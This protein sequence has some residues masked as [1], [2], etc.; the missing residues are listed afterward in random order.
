[1]NE[2]IQEL[3]FQ[4]EDYADNIVDMG[5]EFYE[6]YTNKFAELI[7]AECL[8]EVCDEVQY[9]SDWAAADEV[10]ARVRKHFGFFGVEEF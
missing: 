3:A 8:K 7:I 9:Q 10:K 6:S 5:G 2:R 4:A 1:M